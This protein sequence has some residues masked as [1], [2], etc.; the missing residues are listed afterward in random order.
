MVKFSVCQKLNSQL[1]L[2]FLCFLECTFIMFFKGWCKLKD[3]TRSSGTDIV[4]LMLSKQFAKIKYNYLN[5]C[6][7]VGLFKVAGF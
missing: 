7:F 2:I 6:N 3:F 5:S 1:C 4:V